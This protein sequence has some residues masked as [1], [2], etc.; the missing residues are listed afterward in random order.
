MAHVGQKLGLGPVR[1][2]GHFLG[3]LPLRL[4]VFAL[5]DVAGHRTEALDAAVLD[6]DLHVLADPH[7]APIPGQDGHFKV[8]AGDLPDELPPVK[9]FDSLPVVRADQVQVPPAE[10]LVRGI[11]QQADRG[12]IAKGESALGIGAVN[13]VVGM[14]HD[15]PV[16]LLALAHRCLSRRRAGGLLLRG[17]PFFPQP[18][19][20]P[21]EEADHWHEHRGSRQTKFP[22]DRL[23]GRQDVAPVHADQDPP[24]QA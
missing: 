3:F 19:G 15:V 13:D 11:L 24:M 2:F 23:N 18:C 5:G 8:R 21:Q 1:C 16:P 7:F 22:Q 12:G 20:D 14:V 4:S 6:D 17:R 9:S 10:E